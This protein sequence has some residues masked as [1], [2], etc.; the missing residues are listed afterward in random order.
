MEELLRRK[1]EDG[2]A[3]REAAALDGEKG[4]AKGRGGRGRVRDGWLR[5]PRATTWAKIAGCDCDVHVARGWKSVV[6]VR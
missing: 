3:H 2:R 6:W 4:R 5:G 1:V